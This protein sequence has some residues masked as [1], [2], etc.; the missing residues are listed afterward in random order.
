MIN[1]TGP[2]ELRALRREGGAAAFLP[3][4]AKG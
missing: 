2:Y 4:F 3:P 1:P